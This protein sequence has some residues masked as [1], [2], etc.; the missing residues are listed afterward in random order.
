MSTRKLLELIGLVVVLVLTYKL[1]VGVVLPILGWALKFFL[2][3]GS[4]YLGFCA[5]QYVG[6]KLGGKN[7]HYL[8]R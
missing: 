2:V 5:F 6:R 4:I 3:G 1:A 7:K 8:N